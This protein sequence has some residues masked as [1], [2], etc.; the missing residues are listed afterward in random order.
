MF[1]SNG[2]L[3]YSPSDLTGYMS[4]HFATWMDRLSLEQP[5]ISQQ[6]DKPD[7]LMQALAKKG[8]ALEDV[9]EEKFIQ[10]GKTLIKITGNSDTDK[11]LKTKESMQSGIDIIAQARL[12]MGQFRGYADFLVKVP[13][14][15]ND[16]P[17]HLGDWHYEAWDSKLANS[18]KASFIVQLCSYSQMLESMQGILP[19]HIT[20]V[21]G[22]S[23]QSRYS[24]KDYYS[25]YSKL[26]SSFINAQENF[27]PNHRPDPSASKNWENWSDVA[28]QILLE[29]D[30]LSQVADISKS[31]IKKLNHAAI[32]TLEQLSITD[33]EHIPGIHP[34]ILQKRIAQAKIQHTS[35]GLEIPKFE[36]LKPEQGKKVGLALLPPS[37]PLDV[38]FDIEGYPLDVGGLE[39]L[40]GNTYFD[41]HGHR[42]FK[43]FWAHNNEQEKQCFKDFIDWVYQRWIEDPSMHIY[44]YANYEIAACQKLMGRYGVCEDELDQLLRNN[45][46]VDLYKLVKGG[47]LLGAPSYSIKNVELLYRPKRQTEVTNGGESIIVYEQWRELNKQGLEGDNY[48]TSDILRQIRDYNIDDCDSTQELVDWLRAQQQLHNITYVGNMEINEPIVSEEITQRTQLRDRLLLQ[49]TTERKTDPQ[50][51]DIT[52]TLAYCL[53][54]HRRESKPTFWRLFE[55]LGLS[56]IELSDDLQCLA[57][58]HRTQRESFK[59]KPRA[60]KLAYEY[61]FDPAQEFNG[62]QGNFYLLGVEDE[63][64]KSTKV[65]YVKEESDLASGRV[66]VQHSEEPPEII[67]LVPDEYIQAYPIPQAI[68]QIARDYENDP[69]KV[70]HSAILDFLARSRPKIKNH[71]GPIAPS[72]IPDERF[73]QITK[74][75]IN[76]DNSYLTIQGPPGAGKTFNGKKI[77]AQ[78]LKNGARV[79]VASN[80]HKAINNLVIGTA[81]YCVKNQIDAKIAC[82][83]DNDLNLE[84]C[85]VSILKN[86]KLADFIQPACVVGTT[87]WGFARDDMADQLDYL[88]IDEAGQVAIAN[89]IAMSRSAKNLI[90][91]GDQMQLGQPSQV[92]HPVE[93][94][95]SVLDYLLKDTPTIPN[96]M[97]VFLGTT[98]R[99]H[100]KVNQ[101][102]SKYIYDEKLISHPDNDL[103]V[104]DVPPNYKGPLNKNAG[105]IFVPVIHEGNSQASDEEV[106][107][108]K[109]LANTLL[110]RTFH[111]GKDE[112]PTR[113]IGWDDILFVAPY[114]HQ[115]NKLQTALGPQAKVGSVDK[116]QGQE[117][118]IVILSMCASNASESPRGINF[119][120]N[121]NRLNVALSR[122][123]SL[124]IVVGNPNLSQIYVDSI[125]QLK[126]LNLFDSLTLHF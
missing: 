104:V 111:P 23:S 120:L 76:L 1:L 89:L 30:H 81:K 52:E 47:L 85:G 102:I 83:K 24:V 122:A 69:E 33:K 41:N 22:N 75:V 96:D 17:S 91:M 8:L 86:D 10:Q 9:Q 117:A 3:V 124:A 61:N 11:F 43:D 108:I 103:R 94:G 98:F 5:H 107:E 70:E 88:F 18:V 25:Y 49:S 19:K 6:K 119:L 125:E 106:E 46:F 38:F 55:R 16:T 51:A 84:E 60:R 26:L 87:A 2:Q 15:D 65:T 97:G 20:V 36:I 50:R 39:Y 42:Q 40:W 62:A 32:N 29:Q 118:P 113:S 99:M 68:D 7:P 79:G 114:N 101:F 78:L 109:Q 45:V 48:K 126:S 72:N 121:K 77:I 28:K 58:C 80:S 110:G 116:F 123:Q 92:S 27:N 64:G 31:Q 21:L 67:T 37:S 57:N 73:Q 12:E 13:H 66:V 93:S 59:H 4:S 34:E 56:H 115:V 53:E 95:L 63:D 90:L 44:H 35:L 105:I 74:A 82:T 54:F 100:S 14:N 112:M 71:T